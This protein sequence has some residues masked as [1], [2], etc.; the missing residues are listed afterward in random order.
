MM[1]T[2]L[3]INALTDDLHRIRPSNYYPP[4]GFY[5]MGT[6]DTYWIANEDIFFTLFG[7]RRVHFMQLIE[8]MKLDG[9]IFLC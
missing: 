4:A 1:M 8:A 7:F 5:P 2:L 3:S 9:I 6:K